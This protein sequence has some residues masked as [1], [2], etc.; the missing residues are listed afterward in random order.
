MQYIRLEERYRRKI[1]NDD[2]LADGYLF[3]FRARYNILWQYPVTRKAWAPKS[4]SFI[5]NDEVHINFGKEVVNNYFD[6]NRFFTG[7]A[8]HVN[9]SDQIQF[10]YMNL[11]QQLPAGNRYRALHIARVAYFHNLDLRPKSE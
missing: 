8:Y 1:R 4:L 5:L 11:F 7:F 9:Q 6:Q 2:E 3:N 10:G